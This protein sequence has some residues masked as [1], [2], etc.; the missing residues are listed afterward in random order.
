M[1]AGTRESYDH[2]EE[3]LVAISAKVD[4]DGVPC[5]TYIGPDGAGH[6]VKMVHNGIL[7]ADI[8][9]NAESYDLLRQALGMTPAEHAPVFR[10][11]NSGRLQL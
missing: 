4:R 11:W 10:N 8:Q 1:P 6:F 2:V 3:L 9:L 5:C 7:Y